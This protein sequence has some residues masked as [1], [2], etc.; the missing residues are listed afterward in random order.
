MGGI[1]RE[2]FQDFAEQDDIESI[3]WVGEAGDLRIEVCVVKGM[4]L[5][6]ALAVDSLLGFVARLGRAEVVGEAEIVV[7]ESLQEQ[8]GEVGVGAQLKQ[9]RAGACRRWR[10]LDGHQETADRLM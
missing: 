8:G 6:I 3:V 9:A 2:M 7:V 4:S 5:S 10:H 1:E